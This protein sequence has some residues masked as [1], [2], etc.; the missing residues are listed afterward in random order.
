MNVS[1]SKSVSPT[2]SVHSGDTLT[3]TLNVNIVGNS[4]NGAVITDT[5]PNNVT[6]A[7]SGANNPSYLPTPVYNSSTSQLTWN[8]P[9]LSP[10][11]YQLTYSTK[12]N[13]L[14]LGGTNI[15]NGAQLTY[16]GITLSS[17]VTVGVI[18]QYTVSVGVYNESGELVKVILVEL[19]SQPINSLTLQNS[20]ITSLNGSS[21]A[22]QIYYQ[23]S[24]IG[25]WNG[26]NANGD[27]AANGVYHVKVDSVSSTGVVSS[28]TQQVMVSRSLY[29]VTV[30]VY[31]EAGEVVKHLYTYVDDPGKAGV[32][33]VQ[34][35]TTVIKPSYN[36]TGGTPSQLGVILS[37]GTT[38]IWDGR[39]DA[40][41]FVQ[42]GQYYVEVHSL[43]GTGG[44]TTVTEEVSVQGADTSNLL[45]A[46]PNVLDTAKGIT[47]TTFV[48][49]STTSLTLHATIYTIA[50]ERVAT[51]DGPAGQNTVN[52]NAQGLASGIYIAVVTAK[53]AT[54]NFMGRQ[55][56]KV[57]ILH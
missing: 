28:V 1:F 13:N 17:A 6:Y 27:P 49:N 18:G 56:L 51:L 25:T 55:T 10:G 57:L 53:D 2:G 26:T 5:L 29:K 22:V 24:L 47:S 20:V 21:N 44:T 46:Q 15:A 19:L 42:T 11:T 9:P 36:T 40:G 4:V 35:S 3:Y 43:D 38:I 34:L 50:G 52:W 16:S 32:M 8:L 37:N 7:G 41:S 45:A 23:N 30:L 33:G 54:G 12:V 48:A 39:S 31:N 14:V